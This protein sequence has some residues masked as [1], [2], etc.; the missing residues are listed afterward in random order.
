MRD[1]SAAGSLFRV[2]LPPAGRAAARTTPPPRPLL[3]SR[4]TGRTPAAPAAP[5]LLPPARPASSSAARPGAQP[6]ARQPGGSACCYWNSY[7]TLCSHPAQGLATEPTASVSASPS[8]PPASAASSAAS[9]SRPSCRR[10]QAALAL[11]FGPAELPSNRVVSAHPSKWLPHP[12]R[13]QWIQEV[14]TEAQTCRQARST[15]APHCSPPALRARTCLI[16][17][18]TLAP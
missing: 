9:T 11:H 10:Q 8:G 2:Y 3:A 17:W 12:G 6:P 7:G 16:R 15:R 1:R 13:R 5:R 18:S 14:S 4:R